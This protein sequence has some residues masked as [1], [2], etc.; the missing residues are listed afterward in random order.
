MAA[1]TLEIRVGHPTAKTAPRRAEN[2]RSRRLAHTIGDFAPA[3]ALAGTLLL[4]VELLVPSSASALDLNPVHWVGDI[5]GAGVSLGSG[6]VV[7]GF[8]AIL[9]SLFSGLEARLTLDVLT[10]LTSSDNQTGGHIATLYGLTSGM[11]LGLLGAVL[12]VSFLRYW[13]AGLSLSGRGGFEAVEGLL[14][15]LGGVAALLV[16]PTVF[17]QLIAL[18]NTASATILGFGALRGE[19]AT[20]INTVVFVT[21]TPGGVV[22]LFI[23][24]VVAVAGALL[25]LGLLFMKVMTG[26]ALTFLYVAMPLVLILWPIDEIAWLARYALRAFFALVIIPVVWALIFATFAAVSVNALEFQGAHGFVN[27]VTQPLV[28]IAM[29]W[30]AVT[31]PRTLFKMASSGLGMSRHGG[32]FISHAGS[33]IAARQASAFLTEHGILPSGGRGGSGGGGTTQ[34]PKGAS[35]SGD[36]KGKRGTGDGSDTS[37]AANVGKAVEQLAGGA[38]GPAGAAVEATEVA[39][40]AAADATPGSTSQNS[41]DEPD[42]IPAGQVAA[43]G[44]SVGPTRPERDS[45]NPLGSLPSITNPA[46]REVLK[47]AIAEIKGSEAP[48][49]EA[50]HNALRGLGDDVKNRLQGAYQ[51][52]GANGV[53]FEAARLATSDKISNLQA[54]DAMTVAR[55]A[56]H[57][58]SETIL[59]I[60]GAPASA[61]PPGTP[62]PPAAPPPPSTTGDEHSAS[63]DK[64]DTAWRQGGPGVQTHIDGGDS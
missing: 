7:R 9:N 13:L 40:D 16:W 59:H 2:R 17:S 39:T 53:R 23:A 51:S 12:S 38:A 44:L 35:D 10:W 48:S 61:P 24:I 28:A 21:F 14:R 30:L 56:H 50:A 49:A 55:A 29:L 3:L 52:G 46:N 6:V 22:G 26:A 31:I 32:G 45:K 33:Y 18:G 36:S 60:P 47:K 42:G 25:F 1:T 43:Q 5:V 15:T 11:A 57:G 34:Q 37:G 58:M 54:N 27:Q 63:A 8:V 20:I 62:D 64:R 41:A 4:V 19:V